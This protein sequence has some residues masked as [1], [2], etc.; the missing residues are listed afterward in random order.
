MSNKSFDFLAL[1]D[2]VF[3]I[4]PW[5]G[6]VHRR[7]IDTCVKTSVMRLGEVTET[8]Q[9][10]VNGPMTHDNRIPESKWGTWFFSDIELARRALAE[11]TVQLKAERRANLE[12]ELAE[13]QRR[14]NEDD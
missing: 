1:G 11:R 6:I 13:V 7:I 4:D 9:F 3:E 2:D 12:K 10:S 5:L 8:V 14:L